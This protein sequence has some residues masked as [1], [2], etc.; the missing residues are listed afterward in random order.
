M[1]RKEIQVLDCTVRDG[2]LINQ[3][4]FTDEFV[5]ACY[6]AAC[7]SGVDWW[8][9]GKKLEVSDHYPR[10][11]WGAWNFCEDDDIQR[12]VDSYDGDQRAKIAVM[13]DVGRVDVSRLK[14]IDQT[15]IDMVRTACYVADIDKGI[16]LVRRTKDLGYA[17]T[18]NI[19]AP[20]AAIERDL[21]EGLR[22]INEVEEIDFLYLVDSF[23]SLYSEQI[24][25]YVKLYRE[26]APSKQLGFHGHNNQQLAFANTQ[27]AIIDGVNLLDATVNAVSYTHL[28]LPTKRIV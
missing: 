27:Q 19:M 4:Q 6:R 21:V 8:E 24:S 15:P 26:H 18:L 17:T 10:A 22:E 1:Y 20:S 2:G 3:Y 9:I 14:P 7:E 5:K 23:G 11:E 25:S 12:V 28:T 13:Y 16:D